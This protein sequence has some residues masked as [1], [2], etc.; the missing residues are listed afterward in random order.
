MT[1]RLPVIAAAL[2]LSL[3][4][5]S[6]ITAGAAMP[7]QQ[8]PLTSPDAL[9]ALLLSAPDVGAALASDD[10]VVTTDVGKAWNDSAH[11]A[12]TNCLAIAG[13]AQQGVYAGSGSTA[14]HGQ[15]L[16]EPPSAPRW[17]HYAVQAV[18]TFPTA[19]AAADFFTASQRGW[20]ACSNRELN[21]AQPIGPP[22]VW[23]V[24][25]TSTDHDVLAVSRVQQGPQRWACQRALTVHSNV[26]VDVEA[27]SLD[28]PTTAA[29]TIAGQIAGRLPVA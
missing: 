18:V 14:V 2:C 20:A 25:Q 23:S 13:A 1:P 24:G 17:S 10:V 3:S 7:A 26:A 15:V 9:P 12:D 29:S 19:Q 28:G 4:G 5:C 22:Q 6:A 27:C 8:A 11:F 16:R 21:Y